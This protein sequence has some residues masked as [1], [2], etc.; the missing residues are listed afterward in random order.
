MN[1]LLKAAAVA[2]SL[3]PCPWAL[4]VDMQFIG[5]EEDLGGTF[6]P[7]YQY[8]Q[9]SISNWRSDSE[10]H[11]FSTSD[12]IGQRYYA[13][14]GWALFGTQFSF[15]NANPPGVA[16]AFLPPE[17][18]I[19]DPN[20]ENL[21]NLPSFV[22]Q[23]QI[24][25]SRIAAGWGYALIDDPRLQAG[26]RLW[27][28]DGENYPPPVGGENSNITGVVP[29]V[30]LGLLDG[31]DTITGANPVFDPSA[32]WGFQVGANAPPHFRVGVMTD[33]LDGVQFSPGEVFLTQV[34][35]QVPVNTVSTG[36]LSPN[37]F[38]DMHFFDIINAQPGDQFLF[39]AMTTATGATAG[40]S[41]FSFDIIVP[42]VSEGADFNGDGL[43]DGRD[44]LAWQR[45]QSPNP[46]SA[47]DLALW[48]NEYG[49]GSLAAVSVP[50]PA[51]ALLAFCAA[52]ACGCVSRK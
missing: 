7:C 11:F 14:D 47:S 52:L 35:D 22:T 16:N 4:A 25:S 26:V 29:Y 41:G 37:R 38:V 48:Q 45:G 10:A 2:V 27:T 18:D 15:P 51:A 23:H 36:T 44:F 39:S 28:F 12:V 13:K 8:P 46:L 21:I 32:R 31:T 9:C 3:L 33:G 6:F 1:R 5:T 19:S 34:V 30:K 24:F 42:F 43:V 17:V 40:I 49:A 20:F 50:E